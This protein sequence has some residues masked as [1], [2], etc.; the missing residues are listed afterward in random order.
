LHFLALGLF[1]ALIALP[2]FLA[3]WRGGSLVDALV[4]RRSRR[5]SKRRRR[6]TRAL[7][8]RKEVME[9]LLRAEDRRE[10]IETRIG[11]RLAAF[12]RLGPA[13]PSDLSA[14]DSL[15]LETEQA[16]LRREATFADYLDAASLQSETIELLLHEVATLRQF[17]G[18]DVAA[19]PA[20]ESAGV[21]QRKLIAS[22][23][24][25]SRRRAQADRNLQQLRG[26]DMHQPR[27]ISRLDVTI[28]DD[29]PPP[30]KAE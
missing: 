1:V 16:I 30:A 3:L 27:S 2:I 22:L 5:V 8:V 9:A 23:D 18:V 29:S 25:A 11:T 19:V 10:E 20:A 28:G 14:A 15:L 21:A 4:E 26:L 7:P 13:G 6:S 24:R 12:A 17:A